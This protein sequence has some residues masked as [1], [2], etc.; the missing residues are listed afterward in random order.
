MRRPLFLFFI[1]LVLGEAAAIF[2]NRTGFFVMALFL[3]IFMIFCFIF[4]RK[5]KKG[6]SLFFI[7]EVLF[8]SFFLAGGFAFFKASYVNDIDRILSKKTLTGTLTGQVEYVRQNVEGE[9]QIT[10]RENSFIVNESHLKDGIKKNLKKWSI[11]SIK[12]N[13]K[14]TKKLQGKC[15]LVKIP[16]SK[17]KIYP[18]DFIT[19]TG[20]L[21][22]IE[23]PTNPGQFNAKIY[24]YSLGIRYQF[25]GETLTRRRE[26][27]LSLY[28]I[29]GS[30]R[31]KIDAVYR[32]ILSDTEYAL[33][34]AIFLGDKADLSKEQKLLYEEN[35]MAHLL[36]VSGLHVSIVGGMLFRFLRKKGRSYAFSCMVGSGILFFYAVMTGFGNSVFRAAVMFFCFLLAQY[37]GAEY[38]M[39]SAMSLA[40]I[41]MLLDHPWRLMES[42]CVIS[43]AS[44]FSIGMILPIAKELLKKRSKNRLTEGEFPIESPKRKFI[45]QAFFANVIISMSITPLLLRF[46]YQW[47]PYSI[48]LNLFVIPAMSPLLMSAVLGGILGF[49]S[50]VAAFLGCIPAV[51]LLR[52]F[53]TVFRF[54]A[55]IPGA[56]IVTGCPPWWKV[57]LLYLIEISFFF[58]WY[59]RRKG[60]SV[61]LC[62]LL[63]AGRCFSPVPALK[64]TMLDVGQGEC[65]FIKMPTGESLLIDG[66]STS[67]KNIAEYTMIPAL[68]YYG[69]DHLDYVIITHT[70][71]DHISGI[72]DLFEQNY[73]IKHVILPDT[74]AMNS[75][76]PIQKLGKKR[77]YSF[78]K[79]SKADQLNFDRVHLR[80][81]HPKK[82]WEVEDTNS[83]SF[84]FY[85]TYD[86]FTMLFTGDLNGEQEPLL[87]PGKGEKISCINILKVA[88]HGS[89][90]S[91]TKSFLEEFQPQKAI[92]S[93]GKNNLYGHPHK[94]TIKRLQ[95]NGADIYGTLWGGAIVIESDSQEYRINYFKRGKLF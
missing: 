8:W 74:K 87:E 69:T 67:K 68:K 12:R 1:G 70:D 94:E 49:F 22:A 9:Y 72:R 62:L 63:I 51:I 47:S 35:G 32:H 38:D 92:L 4:Y 90:N 29:A 58:L 34:K 43:F 10:V 76:N 75:R 73:P 55:Q 44:I 11:S 54:M 71:E 23:N 86:K 91:T 79:I 66:G 80:C 31:E 56:V 93:A 21:K 57:L 15:R 88:H 84:V 41:L 13:L 53:E 40:G 82:D 19:C 37:F 33:L 17:G 60:L 6:Q 83:S 18:G 42:G 52:I 25:F 61:L 95:E 85:L 78:L 14:L 27:P 81:L 5:V 7:Y 65:I 39:I 20:K 3:L 77:G 28:R 46:F 24:Y 16:V 48:L 26:S 36:A 45:R 30:V 64:I 59:Y 50:D 2:L 89:K